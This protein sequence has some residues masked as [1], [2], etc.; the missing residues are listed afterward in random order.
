MDQTSYDAIN[1]G[2]QTGFN[3]R[4]TDEGQTKDHV[5][6]TVPS[7]TKQETYPEL[8]SIGGMKEW[9]G[10]LP[11]DSINQ[12]AFLVKNRKFGKGVEV[13]AD[14]VDDFNLATAINKA[15]FTVNE[16]AD[17]ASELPD[18]LVWAQLERGFDTDGYDGQFFFDTD[19]PVVAEDGSSTSVSNF[20]GGVGRPWYL[21][22][23]RYYKM[24]IIFQ[25]RLKAQI[26]E[27]TKS[28]NSNVIL[29]DKL[30]WRVKMR[31]EAAF[32]AW[33]LIYASREE[34]TVANYEAAR[35]A[36]G[37]IVGANGRQLNIM[38]TKLIVHRQ[39]EGRAR[40]LI[41]NETLPNGG[42]NEWYKTAEVHVERRL[43]L[44]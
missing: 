6:V 34:L 13:D 1:T 5:A 44:S 36:M 32:G 40:R 17:V 8:T 15:M 30:L 24:P 4:L 18:D 3:E 29:R 22:D 38:P 2:I 31:C 43:T 19:H 9:V 14:D 39:D 37:G 42:T 35:A 7:T 10:D 26:T 23:D 25:E 11:I 28:D 20:G 21:V 16:L 12:D 27:A 33:P 41:H